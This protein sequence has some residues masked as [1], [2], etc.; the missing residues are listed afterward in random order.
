MEKKTLQEVIVGLEIDKL[1]NF[2]QDGEY[3]NI[4]KHLNLN[5]KKF[6]KTFN[7]RYFFKYESNFICLIFMNYQVMIQLYTDESFSSKLGRRS[8]INKLNK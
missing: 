3:A 2:Y 6:Y 8:I 1:F 7:Q 5:G 4:K